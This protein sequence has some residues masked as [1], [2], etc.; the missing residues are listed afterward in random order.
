MPADNETQN[1]SS[2]LTPEQLAAQ[3]AAMTAAVREAVASVMV[4]LLPALKEMA[5]TPEKLRE[6]NKP[7]VDPAKVLRE[8][9]ES[10]KSKADE[11]EQR[12]LDRS[13]RDAC[14]HQDA[15]GRDALCLI[16]N[17][18]DHQPRAICPICQDVI[19][20]KEWRIASSA[21]EAIKLTP[22]GLGPVDQPKGHAYI[23]LA[24]R[25]YRRVM[26]LE[27]RS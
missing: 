2:A 12:R 9:R 26:A 13:R 19:H 6:A 27:S 18:P 20:P 21:E 1:R 5:I 14:L 7:Y 16:H 17:Y 25:D 10:L 23:A 8:Q 15:N 22:P 24:H 11:A 4:G 3:N